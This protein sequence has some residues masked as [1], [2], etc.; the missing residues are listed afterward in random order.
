MNALGNMGD[1]IKMQKRED[2]SSIFFCMMEPAR[3]R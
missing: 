3:G 1:N 2:G